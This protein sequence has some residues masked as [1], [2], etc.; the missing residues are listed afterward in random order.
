MGS[1][2]ASESGHRVLAL[3]RRLFSLSTAGVWELKKTLMPTTNKKRKE[4]KTTPKHREKQEDNAV[5]AQRQF[6][7][8]WPGA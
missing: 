4:K 3:C 7:C 5:E 1:G 8:T 6:I 2:A